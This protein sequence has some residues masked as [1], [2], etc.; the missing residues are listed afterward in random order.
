[1]QIEN[2]GYPVSLY[3][4]WYHHIQQNERQLVAQEK[5]AESVLTIVKFIE[6]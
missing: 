1:M 5:L 3:F 4:L 6:V 2:E